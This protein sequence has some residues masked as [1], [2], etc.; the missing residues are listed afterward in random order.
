MRRS[1]RWFGLIGL[2]LALAAC[3]PA[4]LLRSAAIQPELLTPD[5]DGRNEVVA[6]RYA[7]GRNA[8]V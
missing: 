1:G 3:R 4:P 2:L 5:G 7:L 8:I 6:I